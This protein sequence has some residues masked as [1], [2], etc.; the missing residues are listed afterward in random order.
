MTA[1]ADKQNVSDEKS[2]E[3]VAALASSN[4]LPPSVADM[5]KDDFEQA[6]YYSWKFIKMLVSSTPVMFTESNDLLKVCRKQ[7]QSTYQF[8]TKKDF[9]LNLASF[10]SSHVTRQ[11]KQLKTLCRILLLTPSV[12]PEFEDVMIELMS[13][14]TIQGSIIDFTFISSHISELLASLPVTKLK[15][16]LVKC[17]G[18]LKESRYDSDYKLKIVHALIIPILLA[19]FESSE[20]AKADFFDKSMIT[21]VCDEIL[22]PAANQL[23][24]QSPRLAP[25][26]AI[27]ESGIAAAASAGAGSTSNN[28]S[29]DY[30]STLVRDNAN[31]VPAPS[32]TSLTAQVARLKVW[33]STVYTLYCIYNLLLF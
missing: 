23:L 21:F 29:I 19:V 17:F 18:S 20:I 28:D 16:L 33:K 4:S 1:V 15:S 31:N 14:L 30:G 5:S 27:A 2:A 12:S 11:H 8:C 22:D 10:S 6:I 3:V 25:L 26:T 13:V 9:Q 24:S 7:F 32:S